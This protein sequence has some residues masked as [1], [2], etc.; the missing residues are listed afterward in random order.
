MTHKSD[1]NRTR[2]TF[3]PR[4]VLPREARAEAVY[5]NHSAVANVERILIVWESI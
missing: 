5:I 3:P 2:N 1:E 4:K